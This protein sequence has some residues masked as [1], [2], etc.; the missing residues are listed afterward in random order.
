MY[1]INLKGQTFTAVFQNPP[2]FGQFDA[3]VVKTEHLLSLKLL[4]MALSSW[5]QGKLKG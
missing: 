2:Q 3:E 4:E 1:L 5:T